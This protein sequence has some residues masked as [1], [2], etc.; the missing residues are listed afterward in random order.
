M[1]RSFAPTPRSSGT[2][3]RL[4]GW[5]GVTIRARLL[6]AAVWHCWFAPCLVEP[7]FQQLAVFDQVSVQFSGACGPAAAAAEE[8]DA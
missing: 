8:P 4:A 7:C 5:I 1:G 6:A 3:G 2:S